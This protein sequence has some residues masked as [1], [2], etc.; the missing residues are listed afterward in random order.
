MTKPGA[1]LGKE[2]LERYRKEIA[3]CQL[4][5]EALQ[6]KLRQYVQDMDPADKRRYGYERAID[7]VPAAVKAL[8]TAYESL[9]ELMKA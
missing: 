8:R 1:S 9:G 5:L 6:S 3:G 2:D 7:G 4:Q